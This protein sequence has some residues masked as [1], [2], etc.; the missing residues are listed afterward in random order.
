VFEPVVEILKYGSSNG[1]YRAVPL[2]VEGGGGLAG[3]VVCGGYV[4]LY[5]LAPTFVS[6]LKRVYLCGLEFVGHS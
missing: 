4:M 6:S 3:E 5:K 1:S 2:E